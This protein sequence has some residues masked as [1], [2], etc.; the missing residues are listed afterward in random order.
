MIDGLSDQRITSQLIARLYMQIANAVMVE[1]SSLANRPGV[2]WLAIAR[3]TP[4]LQ[5]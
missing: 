4:A 2:E 3:H 1:Q 5:P